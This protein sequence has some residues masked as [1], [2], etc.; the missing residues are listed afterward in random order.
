MPYKRRKALLILGELNNSDLDWMLEKGRKEK[1]ESDRVLIYEKEPIN[2]LYFV[3]SGKFS[4]WIGDRELAQISAGEVVGEISFL[5][6][7]PPL[8]TVRAMEDSVVLSIPRWQLLSRLRDEHFASRF[9]HGLAKCLSDRMRDTVR[10]LGY[11]L[12]FAELYRENNEYDRLE[13]E[14]LELAETKFKWLLQHSHA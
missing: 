11:D 12:E 5:D 9:Y 6:E 13:V 7:R 8:A 14:R 2:A 1:I 3:L 10:R 4:I